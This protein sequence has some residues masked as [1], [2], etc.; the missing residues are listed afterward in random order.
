MKHILSIP[1]VLLLTF[2]SFAQDK[3]EFKRQL[4]LQKKFIKDYPFVYIPS[5]SYT[6]GNA[7]FSGDQP[8][9]NKVQAISINNFYMMQCEVSNFD[10]LSYVETLRKEDSTAAKIALPD[11]LCW[12]KKGASNEPYVAYYLRHPAYQQ[13]PV[14]G[15]SYNQAVAY[16]EWMTS[17]Y[18]S[19]AEDQKAFKKVLFRLPTEAEWEYAARGGLEFSS[20]P[21]GG[22]Y[23]RNA[24]GERLAN[25]VYISQASV[26][27]DTVWIQ[28]K[29][30]ISDSCELVYQPQVRIL[31]SGFG[32]YSNV[33]GM[34]KDAADVT[35]PV[36]S[37]NPNGYGLYNM[38]GNV[39]EMVDA[40]HQHDLG[41]FTFVEDEVDPSTVVPSG[42]TRGGS[43]ADTGYYG[44]VTTRQFYTGKESSSAERGFRLVMD[45]LEY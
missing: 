32:D 36:R 8:N 20:F 25:M 22:P 14:V 41:Q 26:Y 4:K 30:I 39:A 43:W 29:G 42:I 7:D 40:W 33:D 24:K 13:Y 35:A 1:L 6:M 16:A 3:K 15:V 45:V 10:Y 27:R 31:S 23:M 37:F 17:Q 11:T 44:L 18:N 12:R 5:G 2:S 21:W 38:T 19:R 34:L 28:N 9:Q